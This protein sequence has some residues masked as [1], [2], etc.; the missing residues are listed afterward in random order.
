MCRQRLTSGNINREASVSALLRHRSA[1]ILS[2][3]L[4]EL[5][6]LHV[7]IAACAG[8]S[9]AFA[10]GFVGVAVSFDMTTA[11]DVVDVGRRYRAATLPSYIVS[12]RFF[13]LRVNCRPC[14]RTD[15]R[16]QVGSAVAGRLLAGS[17]I[18]HRRRSPDVFTVPHSV[19]TFE[20]K[21]R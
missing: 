3:F 10:L 4:S 13:V 15:L 14:A 2:T 7:S 18:N 5:F 21:S 16:Q 17:P 12:G 19:L 20:R 1:D 11:G 9:L 8:G 6:Y